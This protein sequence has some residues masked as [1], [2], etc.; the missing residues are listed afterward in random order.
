MK[1]Q[2]L[3]LQINRTKTNNTQQTK[4]KTLIIY[5]PV[6]LKQAANQSKT[7]EVRGQLS[8]KK[9]TPKKTLGT[10]ESVRCEQKS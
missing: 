6:F 1:T 3:L 7:E 9:E 5:L 8:S 4:V 10:L 2:V